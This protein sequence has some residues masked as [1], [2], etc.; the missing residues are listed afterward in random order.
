MLRIADNAEYGRAAKLAWPSLLTLDI[1]EDWQLTVLNGDYRKNVKADDIVTFLSSDGDSIECVA[2]MVD[3]DDHLG[4][5]Y[6]W[7]A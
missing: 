4:V 6:I 7:W 2:M 1:S 3:Y 5:T